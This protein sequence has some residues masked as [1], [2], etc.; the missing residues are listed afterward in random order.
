MLFLGRG[1]ILISLLNLEVP[2]LAASYIVRIVDK[3]V[4]SF[5][6]FNFLVFVGILRDL[7]LTSSR[8]EPTVRLVL[9]LNAKVLILVL[10]LDAREV[11]LLHGLQFHL[12]LCA[13]GGILRN[14]A[15]FIEGVDIPLRVLKELVDIFTEHLLEVAVLHAYLT[16]FFLSAAHFG[17]LLLLRR[18]VAT[19]AQAFVGLTILTRN[20]LVTHHFVLGSM[21]VSS[22]ATVVACTLVNGVVS[23][24][25]ESTHCTG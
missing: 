19:M 23:C 11:Y 6:G 20:E 12:I 24:G 22:G 9:R 16:R 25:V 10:R 7:L 21:L 17:H 5:A 3:T 4:L 13:V 14:M 1:I 15:H 2:L 8:V 18:V